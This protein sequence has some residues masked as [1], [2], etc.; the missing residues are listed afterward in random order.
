MH[1]QQ[2]CKFYALTST[3]ILLLIHLIYSTTH[4]ACEELVGHP[5]PDPVYLYLGVSD[6]T[7]E[8]LRISGHLCVKAEIPI[9][10]R[11]HPLPVCQIECDTRTK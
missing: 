4:N 2:C 3:L 5:D 8:N 1:S 9:S 10:P 7:N 6:L 11:I